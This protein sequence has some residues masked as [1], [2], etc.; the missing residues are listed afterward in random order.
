MNVIGEEVEKAL[1]S[2]VQEPSQSRNETPM[3]EGLCKEVILK[4]NVQTRYHNLKSLPRNVIGP[5]AAQ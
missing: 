4:Y 3:E 5:D 1:D 2:E